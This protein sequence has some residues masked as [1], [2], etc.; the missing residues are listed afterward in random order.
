MVASVRPAC[1]ICL[2]PHLGLECMATRNAPRFKN[3]PHEAFMDED[4]LGWGGRQHR[5]STPTPGVKRA[6][7]LEASPN[8]SRKPFREASWKACPKG[9]RYSIDWVSIGNLEIQGFMV[10]IVVITMHMPCGHASALRTSGLK[11][12]LF[13]P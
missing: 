9:I 7:S 8:G 11:V 4:C 10:I 5:A 2:F 12:S 13:E 3:C 1:T 6:T